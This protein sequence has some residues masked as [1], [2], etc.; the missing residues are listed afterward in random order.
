MLKLLKLTMVTLIYL[1]SFLTL[2]NT[3]TSK[4]YNL[5][6]LLLV[7]EIMLTSSFDEFDYLLT[8]LLSGCSLGTNL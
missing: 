2:V 1:V 4:F 3:L 5:F 6:L 7:T 8:F